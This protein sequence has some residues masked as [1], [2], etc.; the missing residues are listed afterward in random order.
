MHAKLSTFA[1]IAKDLNEESAFRKREAIQLE[2]ELMSVRSERDTLALQVEQLQTATAQYKLEQV[3][4]AAL[5]E[6][7]KAYELEGLGRSKETTDQRDEMI[8]TLA[9]KLEST[10][11]ALDM[12]RKNQRQRRQI[13]FPPRGGGASHPIPMQ[14][15]P[16]PDVSQLSHELTLARKEAQMSDM[17]LAHAQSE[18]ARTEAAYRAKI[19]TL[20]RQLDQM[21]HS[22]G[23]L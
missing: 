9:V 14:P 10:L 20:E 18:S 17:R 23:T 15:P 11:E 12:E 5:K 19:E 6:R 3:E 7:M 16:P 4:H 1:N 21:Y 22:G 2:D 8:R 13:I